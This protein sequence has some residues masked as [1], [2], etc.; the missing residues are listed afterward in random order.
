MSKTISFRFTRDAILT[1]VT[2]IVFR[3]DAAAF[4][5]RRTDTLGIIAAS[6]T[7]LPRVSVGYYSYTFTEPEAGLNYEY[8]IE[9]VYAGNTKRLRQVLETAARSTT[10]TTIPLAPTTYAQM[11]I[12]TVACGDATLAA[13]LATQANLIWALQA[14]RGVALDLQ[15]Q[16]YVQDLLTLAL[17]HV[18][19]RIDTELGAAA[20]DQRGEMNALN[21]GDASSST[22]KRRDSSFTESSS[23]SQTFSR[24]AARS[25]SASQVL[26][27]ANSASRNGS[28]Y[29][30]STMAQAASGSSSRNQSGS[31][32]ARGTLD[33]DGKSGRGRSTIAS[34]VINLTRYSLVAGAP[35]PT[36]SI[37]D[38]VLPIPNP[39]PDDVNKTSSF[40]VIG[41][42][43]PSI[44]G[45]GALGEATVQ[46]GNSTI[47]NI[48]ESALRGRINADGTFNNNLSEAGLPP[49][50]LYSSVS[51]SSSEHARSLVGAQTG[52]GESTFT[53]S[54]TRANNRA[55]SST[56]TSSSSSLGNS[57]STM[58][59]TAHDESNRVAASTSHSES[60]YNSSMTASSI[61]HR[62]SLATDAMTAT[63][64]G[65]R[66]YYSQIF[67]SLKQMWEDTLEAIRRLESQMMLTGRYLIE[68]LGVTTSQAALVG[69]VSLPTAPSM[70][71]RPGVTRSFI[72]KPFDRFI[73]R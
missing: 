64:T 23:S 28:G 22:A 15:Y 71:Q 72:H 35:N 39:M 43:L 24:T 66:E 37:G 68:T 27:A 73:V 1:D 4:G 7:A 26:N 36:I 17:D 11:G 51:G 3:D 46:V 18:R 2:S 14:R 8:V 20:M 56:A 60:L 40:V 69:A 34:G 63:A 47:T 59:S 29:D 54:G 65:D 25:N 21:T 45:V 33:A 67:D 49:D 38:T 62:E 32:L 50:G 10:T 48:V 6:G 41:A 61:G 70:I 19:M 9:Y 12:D 42:H 57:V 31:S 53:S 52:S 44:P 55:D 5:I 13:Y 30:Y 16:Y 58:T